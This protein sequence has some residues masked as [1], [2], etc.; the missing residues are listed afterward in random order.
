MKARSYGYRVRDCDGGWSEVRGCF[1][2]LAEAHDAG[3]E[4]EETSAV[5]VVEVG[6]DGSLHYRGFRA[7]GGS[8]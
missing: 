5:D 3:W 7:A 4:V 2:T 8:K 1:A 6:V